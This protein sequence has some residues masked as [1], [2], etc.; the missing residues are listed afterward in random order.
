MRIPDVEDFDE[1]Y[2]PLASIVAK[3][4]GSFPFLG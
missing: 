2:L 4:S 1:H 3:T